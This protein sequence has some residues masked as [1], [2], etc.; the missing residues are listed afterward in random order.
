[1]KKILATLAACLL[2]LLAFASGEDEPSVK[3]FG[4]VA[5]FSTSSFQGND[6]MEKSLSYP[7]FHVG[8]AAKVNLPYHFSLQT[9][10]YYH[11]KGA[12][13]DF[14]LNYSEL[15][16][17]GGT[18]TI[19]H[20]HEY[21]FVEV[22]LYV[23]WGPDLFLFRPYVEFGPYGGYCFHNRHLSRPA[24][25]G[26]KWGVLSKNDW[27]NLKRWEYGLSFGGGVE[28]WKIQVGVRYQWNLSNITNSGENAKRIGTLMVSAGFFF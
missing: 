6:V 15:G 13:Y 2:P 4:L 20:K 19:Q 17:E 21:S 8:V 10:A 14:T 5:G 1:M 9:G 16:L 25:T 26:G 23:Q 28:I 7:M 11:G 18:E 24:D 22:P 3:G 27:E 12:K